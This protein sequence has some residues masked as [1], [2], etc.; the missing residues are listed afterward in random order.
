MKKCIPEIWEREGNEKNIP[1]IREQEWKA[2]IPG[3]GREQ[4]WEWSVSV[5][6]QIEELKSHFFLWSMKIE[7]SITIFL[8]TKAIALLTRD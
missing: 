3:N 5:W 6:E 7:E 8:S 1:K 4:E 2:F